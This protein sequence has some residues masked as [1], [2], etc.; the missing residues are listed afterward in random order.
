MA[1]PSMT[2][3][4]SPSSTVDSKDVHGQKKLAKNVFSSWGGQIVLILSGFVVP[5]LIDQR[6]G[7]EILGIWDFAWSLISHFALVQA[8]VT[9]S[10]NR[11]V[12]QFRA[13][14]DIDSLNRAVSSVAGVLRVMGALVLVL[15]VVCV[16]AMPSILR[17][18]LS[19]HL[20]EARWVVLLLGTSLAIQVSASV[21][22][23]VLTGC[24]RWDWHNAM[25]ALTYTIMLAGM[26]FSIFSGY[27]IVG[28]ALVNLIGESFGRITRVVL[29]YRVCPGLQIRRNHM[30]WKT[31]REMMGFGGKMFVRDSATLLL[32][33]TTSLLILSYA[34]P[35]A[36]A[37]F[38]RPT[39]LVRTMGSFISKYANVL[40]PTA[41][42][43]H[44]A[45]D[46]LE[47]RMLAIKSTRYNLF[48]CLPPMIFLALTGGD[49]IALWMGAKYANASLVAVLVGAHF[50]S[51]A[52]APLYHVLCGLDKH[53][54]V[55]LV[56]MFGAICGVVAAFVCLAVAGGGLTSVAASFGAPWA[57]VNGIYL[58]FYACKRLRLPLRKFLVDIWRLPLAV[59]VPFTLI[60]VA[61]K[62]LP[63]VSAFQRLIV[64]GLTGGTVLF[65]VY[66]GFVV[67]ETWK[68]M[69]LRRVGIRRQSNPSIPH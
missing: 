31:A 10:I 28:L 47:V 27:G 50:F 20:A 57:I 53:G 58:P 8:G 52:Y 15:T 19:G 67:P 21:Y 7:Q 61:V 30:H 23:G 54:S 69:V 55:S 44:S 66:W 3:N 33:Q 46:S 64:F 37:L 26:V 17:Q 14:D 32:G 62:W 48:L 1:A 5:R 29:A 42:S 11:Y 4:Q 22:G 9:G 51:M 13:Q 25:Y 63:I 65:A 41:S 43:L 2:Y 49:L 6:L 12:A 24:H 68:S 60:I 40:T 36:L 16:W 56:L 35:A 45:G 18:S 34:G 38:S 39:A 59:C